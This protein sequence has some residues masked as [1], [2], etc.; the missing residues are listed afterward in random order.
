[1]HAPI[2]DHV[3]LGPYTYYDDGAVE[4]NNGNSWEPVGLDRSIIEELRRQG[5]E[6]KS[7]VDQEMVEKIREASEGMHWINVADEDPPHHRAFNK[8]MM[9]GMN[10]WLK[11][12]KLKDFDEVKTLEQVDDWEIENDR[13]NEDGALRCLMSTAD[14]LQGGRS[15]IWSFVVNDKNIDVFRKIWNGSKLPPAKKE[16]LKRHGFDKF[17]ETGKMPK[18]LTEGDALHYLRTAANKLMKGGSLTIDLG[19]EQSLE[20][21]LK[22]WN[23]DQL[24]EPERND[25]LRPE[26]RRILKDQGFEERLKEREVEA[27]TEDEAL[28]NLMDAAKKLNGSNKF[29]KI[30]RNDQNYE[31]YRKVWN[32]SLPLEERNILEEHGLGRSFPPNPYD[33]KTMAILYR[34]GL[35]DD[36]IRRMS[37]DQVQAILDLE[38]KAQPVEPVTLDEAHKVFRHWLGKDYD[39]ATL[40]AVLAVAASERLPGDPAWLLIISGPGNAKTETV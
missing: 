36:Y 31:I 9:K 2:I 23:S 39:I 16:N 35:G 28:N 14:K 13:L 10:R 32:G 1:M 19:D 4:D 12:N 38:R 25:L 7:A 5:L 21:F 17:L 27:L 3:K 34:R 18:V 37:R 20:L 24:P 15:P 33:D 22:V 40:D 8:F 29:M 26:E 11:K 6:W 30:D